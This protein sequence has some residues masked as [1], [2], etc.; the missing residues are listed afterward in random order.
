MGHKRNG[1]S[2]LINICAARTNCESSFF[3]SLHVA[4]F[5]AG[6]E[7]ASSATQRF[8]FGFSG[9]P[10]QNTIAPWPIEISV[11]SPFPPCYLCQVSTATITFYPA[12]T[13]VCRHTN[14]HASY[15]LRVL[16]RPSPP[17]SLPRVLHLDPGAS[18]IDFPKTSEAF[19]CFECNAP[20]VSWT[21]LMTGVETG[22]RALPHANETYFR[23]NEEGILC[24][25]HQ[26]TGVGLAAAA[27]LNGGPPL[28]QRG[29]FFCFAKW[30]SRVPG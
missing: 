11:F 23:V 1:E 29:R 6:C 19:V 30:K 22:M 28:A 25:Q 3:T 2:A 15:L 17:L 20:R 4:V 13:I 24:I 16:F 18:E 9:R 5:G 26:V 12:E 10:P 27:P 21:Y 7:F 14:T 8:V